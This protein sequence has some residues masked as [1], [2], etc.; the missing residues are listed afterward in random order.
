MNDFPM[1]LHRMYSC[2]RRWAAGVMVLAGLTASMPASA[3]NEPVDAYPSKSI[4]LLVPFVAGGGTDL[5]SRAIAQKLSEAWNQPVVVEN[6]GGAN[7]TIALDMA[8]K[9]PSD[10]YTLILISASQTVNVSLYR[11]LTYDLTRDFAAI[12]QVTTQPYVLVVN[13]SLPVESVRDLIA[14]AKQK[15]NDLD[16]GSSGIG[17]LSHLSGAWFATLANIRMTHI[18]YRG[19]APAMESVI[20]GHIDLL[21]STLLQSRA[22]IAAGKLRALA[23]TTSTRSPAMPTV[24][25]MVEAGVSGFVVA[26]WYGIVAPA[27]TPAPIVAKLNR[28][29]VRIL[30]LPEVRE[31]LAADGSDP[32]GSSSEE[33]SAHIRSEIAKWRKV[34]AEADIRPE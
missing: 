23:V 15:P 2:M 5:V 1:N 21:F 20:G 10:G 14:F 32:V 12:T 13:P 8:A 16:Y 29:I 11:N 4:R 19:G 27:G 24:P 9:A 34:I 30:R 17:G 7:G 31:R 26:G 28:E 18:P 3:Q 6:H 22:Q 33:F 25:T